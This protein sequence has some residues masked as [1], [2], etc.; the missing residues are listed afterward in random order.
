M[1]IIAAQDERL[2]S[3][4]ERRLGTS[5]E[6]PQVRWLSALADGSP[7][8]VVVY[9]RFSPRNCELTIATDATK[10]WATRASL[11]AIFHV[12]FKQWGLRRVTFIVRS[13]NQRSIDL[14]ERLGASH[15][16]LVRETFA[17]GVHGVVLGLLKEDCRW[18]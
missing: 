1:E 2:L 17:D 4:A 10:R 8:F 9:S 6:R 16:G 7:V 3:W 13:D 11:R 15:E 14:C 18:C 12:P 5:W